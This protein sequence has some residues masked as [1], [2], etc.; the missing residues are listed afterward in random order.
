MLTRKSVNT[1]SV[2]ALV[3]MAIMLVIALASE[4]SPSIRL[5][6]FLIVVTLFLI[7][8]TLRLILSRQERISRK[9]ADAGSGKSASGSGQAHSGASHP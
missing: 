4:L 9:E 5:G 2:I 3:V 8:V 7:R 6:L 1:Y